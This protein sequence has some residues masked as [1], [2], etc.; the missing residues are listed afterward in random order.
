MTNAKRTVDIRKSKRTEGDATPVVVYDGAIV[1]DQPTEAEPVTF[2]EVQQ[3]LTDAATENNI[4]GTAKVISAADLRLQ[5]TD[6][7][8]PP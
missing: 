2:A 7:D 6:A 3:L 8:L 4:P 1:L 5:W